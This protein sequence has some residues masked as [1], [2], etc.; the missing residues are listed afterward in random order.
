MRFL[1]LGLSD[2]VPD[3]KTIWMFR[4]RLTRA[5]AIDGLFRRFDTAIRKAGYIAMSG[6]LVDNTLVAAP[7]QRNTRDEKQAVKAGRSA[8][9]NLAGSAGEGAPERRGPPVGRSRQAR[10]GAT[11]IARCWT[12]PSRASATRRTRASTDVIA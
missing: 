4:E 9:E 7:K 2:R 12:L 6:Q 5:G 11:G 1:G 10:P 8:H 3:A